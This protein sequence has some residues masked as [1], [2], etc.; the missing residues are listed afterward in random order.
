MLYRHSEVFRSLLVAADL[1]LVAAAWVGA[2]Y[3]SPS[4]SQAQVKTAVDE[5]AGFVTAETRGSPRFPPQ[6]VGVPDASQRVPA[7][8]VVVRRSACG[9]ATSRS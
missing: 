6:N 5:M 8:A 2:Y 7:R 4:L 3:L 9:K 1:T